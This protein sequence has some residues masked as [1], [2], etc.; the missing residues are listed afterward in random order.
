MGD[1]P[2]LSMRPRDCSHRPPVFQAEA[3]QGVYHNN[4]DGRLVAALSDSE[5]SLPE[6]DDHLVRWG[7]VL[8]RHY[9]TAASPGNL[10]S[11]D[12]PPALPSGGFSCQIVPRRG[13]RRR[14]APLGDVPNAQSALSLCVASM[15]SARL[16]ASFAPSQKD[17]APQRARF[18]CLVDA[19]DK[20]EA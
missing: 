19:K 10:T 12:R 6:T 2:F 4:S 17:G 20:C 3:V 11:F 7:D 5:P 15:E 18:L 1:A 8:A 9:L 13:L 16:R 14:S